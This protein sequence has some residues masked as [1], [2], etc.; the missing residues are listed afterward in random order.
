M[1]KNF[2]NNAQGGFTLIELI[3]VIVILGILAATAMPKFMNMSGE[4]RA[5][6]ANAMLGTVR[7]A[8][9][10]DYAKTL[11]KTGKEEFPTATA[12]AGLID[13][14]A[15]D[16]VVDTSDATKMVVKVASAT[17]PETCAVTYTVSTGLSVVDT[18]GC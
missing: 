5:A 1:K 16:Y 18:T 4:A 3:V 2:K 9:A 6:S 11:A 15:G 7:S 14:S 8:V 13:F 17:T 12:L 10:M